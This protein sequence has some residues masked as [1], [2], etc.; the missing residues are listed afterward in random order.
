MTGWAA[1]GRIRLPLRLEEFA[2]RESNQDGIQRARRKANLQAQFIAVAPT[3]RVG[4]QSSE[5]ID[6]LGRWMTFASHRS[7]SIYVELKAQEAT[8]PDHAE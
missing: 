2:V 5:D 7:K 6:R 8:L 3:S 4:R 1:N